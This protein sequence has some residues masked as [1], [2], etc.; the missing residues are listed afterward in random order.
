M[1]STIG[2][3]TMAAALVFALLPC[4]GPALAE[5][6]E[7]AW[8]AAGFL[9]RRDFAGGLVVDAAGD[10]YLGGVSGP[11][12]GTGGNL[13]GRGALVA[14]YDQTGQQVWLAPAYPQEQL[15]HVFGVEIDGDGN[16]FLAGETYRY[17]GAEAFLVKYAPAGQVLW[18]RHLGTSSNEFGRDV[19]VDDQGNSYLAGST[20]GILTGSVNTGYDGFVAKYSPTGSLL[21]LR[22]YPD[23]SVSRQP[24][25]IAVSDGDMFIVGPQSV[26][27]GTLTK[28]DALGDV[29]WSVAPDYATLAGASTHVYDLTLDDVGNIYTCGVTDTFYDNATGYQGGDAVVAK[30]D[31][32]GNLIWQR[33]LETGGYDSLSAIQVDPLGNI[34]V[35]GGTTNSMATIVGDHDAVFA[36]FANNGD[37]LWQDAYRTPDSDSASGIAFDGRQSI[38]VTG[39]TSWNANGYH[40]GEADAFL[41]RYNLV[42]EPSG[43]W[44]TALGTTLGAVAAGRSRCAARTPPATS[45]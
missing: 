1:I 11:V 9:N 7:L 2:R 22:Q 13:G 23:D 31:G 27:G 32:A 17:A 40:A 42:P 39:S 15:D 18:E 30:H 33:R 6:Y 45:G 12:Y 10:P 29:Q 44:L 43:V 24:R 28:L 14:K 4:G 8:Q 20:T 3:R 34:Y 26:Q 19:A 5:S 16:L 21:L 37:L 35:A 41:L 38:Y 36:K 25:A